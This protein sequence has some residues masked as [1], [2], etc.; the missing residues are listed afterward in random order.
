MIFHDRADAGQKLALALQKFKNAKNTIILALPRGGVVVGFETAEELN[1]PLD[2]IVPRKIGAPDNEEFAIGAI[3]ESGEGIFDQEIISTYDISQ[4]YIDKTV[5]KEKKE[6]ER[7][8]KTYRGDRPSLELKDKTV[9][10]VD[11]GIATGSTMRAAIKSVKTKQ[12]KKVIVAVP[13]SAADSA[14]EIKKEVDEFICLDIPE[15][16]GAVG[17]FYEV[18]IQTEDNEV[19]ELLQKSEGFGK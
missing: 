11:D 5:A 7:R 18:F 19:I 8:L 10:I 9:I 1:L 6:A 2:I 14:A 17:A 12:A 16:F 4:D 13:T 3:T 15:Y